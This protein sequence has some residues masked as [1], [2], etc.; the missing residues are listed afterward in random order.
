MKLRLSFLV[1]FGAVSSFAF[2]DTAIIVGSAIYPN[3]GEKWNLPGAK[4]DME[5]MQVA[6]KLYG[7][8]KIIALTG[9]GAS[10]AGILKALDDAVQTVKPTERFV[11]Y[12][13]GHGARE[14]APSILPTDAKP[15]AVR[16][17]A[18]ELKAKVLA[19]KAASRTVILD[20][21]FAGGMQKSINIFTRF[22][23]PEFASSKGPEP[24][25]GPDVFTQ[26]TTPSAQSD[27]CY[28]LAADKT[29]E[30]IELRFPDGERRGLFTYFLSKR[31]D[32]KLEP[33][34][35]VV[36]SV[37]ADIMKEIEIF[38]RQQNPQVTPAF[39]DKPIFTAPAQVKPEPP[40][41]PADLLQ[42]FTAQR[43]DSTKMELH[44]EP[45]E[46]KVPIGQG[47][48]LV[49]EIKEAGYFLILGERGG[50]YYRLYPES[51]DVAAAAVQP[52]SKPFLAGYS[53]EVGAELAKGY[54]FKSLAAAQAVMD[55][56]PRDSLGLGGLT[57]RI[58]SEKATWDLVTSAI[59]IRVEPTLL[60]GLKL[61]SA[62][63]FWSILKRT[64]DAKV[65]FL[66]NRLKVLQTEEEVLS[67]M[68]TPSKQTDSVL[69]LWVNRLVQDSSPID[70]KL[71]P[72]IK[73][74]SDLVK[75]NVA[76]LRSI[77]TGVF[78]KA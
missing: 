66:L 28:V 13:A 75:R 22:Y 57:K 37:Q 30:A 68:D 20:S 74:E 31:L 18:D 47:F 71:F 42:I 78:E 44:L 49:A 3:L 6:L 26:P 70:A 46:V 10:R 63:E 76:V 72:D 11:F 54:L 35:Q 34:G 52:G 32:G 43:R 19:V 23:E 17:K 12:F 48:K 21:C 50:E 29:Q 27:I 15:G 67:T 5:S 51:D 24:T 53:D 38:R 59:Q 65:T 7:F 56:C 69:M 41:P 58:R 77:L 16:I 39:V 25:D 2:A 40:I 9:E 60:G 64:N 36:Q 61:K 33:W 14:P 55:A 4:K 45:N 73:P 62:K 8:D 1:L